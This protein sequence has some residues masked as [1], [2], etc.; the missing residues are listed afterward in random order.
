MWKQSDDT[1]SDM[2]DPSTPLNSDSSPEHRQTEGNGPSRVKVRII[3][4]DGT[5][6][7]V[8]VG[9]HFREEHLCSLVDDELCQ[10]TDGESLIVHLY[11]PDGELTGSLRNRWEEGLSDNRHVFVREVLGPTNNARQLASQLHHIRRRMASGERVNL[12]I[13]SSRIAEAA[14]EELRKLLLISQRFDEALLNV[15]VH[16]DDE[17]QR[18]IL[19]KLEGVGLVRLRDYEQFVADHPEQKWRAPWLETERV[20]HRRKRPKR[21][22]RKLVSS[23][24]AVSE[25]IRRVEE[26]REHP[27]H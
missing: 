7:D 10:L 12:A 27:Q 16:G 4:P 20:R 2:T 21:P 25:W 3:R 19:G 9:G 5:T 6:R 15:W 14:R 23:Q 26:D 1:S 13:R 18:A 8:V 11:R 24:E 22:E 17:Q